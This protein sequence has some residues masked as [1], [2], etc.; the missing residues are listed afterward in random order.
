MEIDKGA[1]T[2]AFQGAE[3]WNAKR[4]W[5]KIQS[6]PW[7]YRKTLSQKEKRRE[8]RKEGRKEGMRAGRMEGKRK[9]HI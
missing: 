6:K 4:E 9:L 8:K 5:S 3:L 2:P 7:L 1:L